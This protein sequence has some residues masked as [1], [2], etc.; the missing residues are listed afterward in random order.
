MALWREVTTEMVQSLEQVRLR[1]T[2]E[3]VWG[4]AEKRAE[5]LLTMPVSAPS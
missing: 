2:P 3:V 4:K 5:S 1:L